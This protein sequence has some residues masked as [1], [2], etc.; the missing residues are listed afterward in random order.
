MATLKAV[1]V[2]MVI[3]H[4]PKSKK[5]EPE[6]REKNLPLRKIISERSRFKVKSNLKNAY[7][8]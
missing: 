6:K 8:K 4:W 2:A 7:D 3:S 1:K 5:E